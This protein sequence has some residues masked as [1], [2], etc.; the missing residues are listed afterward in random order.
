M[1]HKIHPAGIVMVVLTI[2]SW[3]L[4]GLLIFALVRALVTGNGWMYLD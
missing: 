3:V 2:L 4:I 1:R